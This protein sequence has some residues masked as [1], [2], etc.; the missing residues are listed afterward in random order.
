MRTGPRLL[1]IQC[2]KGS[3]IIQPS[4]RFVSSSQT[5]YIPLEV[6]ILNGDSGQLSVLNR[7]VV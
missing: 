5:P 2:P 3:K 4:S 7:C 6:F 1:T